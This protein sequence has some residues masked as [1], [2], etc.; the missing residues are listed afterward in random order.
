MSANPLISLIVPI[1][2]GEKHIDAF[3][4][5]YLEQ[6]YSNLELVIVNDGSIDNTLMILEKYINKIPQ[7]K[8]YSQENKG[9]SVARNNG[10]KHASGEYVIFADVDDYIYPDYVSGLYGLLKKTSA[11]VAFCNYKKVVK[12]DRET[13]LQ[14]DNLSDGVIEFNHIQAIND[15]NYRR[16]LTGYSY[17]KLIKKSIFNDI[18]FP[19]DIVYG[20]DFVFTY[21]L[22]KKVEKVVYSEN[23]GYLYFQ[24]MES[25]THIKRDN[26]KRYQ[27]AWKVHMTYL[28]DVKVK[29]PGLVKGAIAK[30]YL[31]AINNTTRIF[32]K[33]RDVIFLRELYSFIKKYSKVVFTD[34]ESKKMVRFLGLL[35][36]ISPKGVC[37]MCKYI[38]CFMEKNS[39]T[40]KRTV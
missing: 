3:M 35:G 38:F 6:K 29:Y 37:I 7:I 30:C 12:I 27:D 34:F 39:I 23:I 11:D 26:T 22:L 13:V 9:P 2:N 28:D 10:I 36:M 40:F 20:E 18:K 1:Y 4:D 31:L 21:N 17:L 15:F 14:N 24:N 8:V 5:Q 33:K 32:D 19:E 16:H 25:A